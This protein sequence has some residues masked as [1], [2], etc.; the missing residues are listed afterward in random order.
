ML[1]LERVSGASECVYAPQKQHHFNFWPHAKTTILN[2]GILWVFEFYVV[3]S[4]IIFGC[5]MKPLDAAIRMQ[6]GFWNSSFYMC[7]CCFRVE[8]EGRKRR[9][10]RKLNPYQR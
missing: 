7:C 10:I 6:C 1:L 9:G 5:G 2:F 4:G 3:R 8:A